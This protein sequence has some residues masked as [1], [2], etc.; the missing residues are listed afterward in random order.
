MQI[1]W[2]MLA[3][4]IGQDSKGAIT[5]IGVNQTV[6]GTPTL[7]A[8]TKRSLLSHLILSPGETLVLGERLTFH[9]RMEAPS[10]KTLA[11]SSGA[12]GIGS[13]PP[14]PEL[15][16]SID[17][18]G[19][20]GFM[21]EEYGTHRLVIEVTTPDGSE[22]SDSVNLYVVRP[23]EQNAATVPQAVPVPSA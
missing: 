14:W 6:F 12:I 3:E 16:A 9:V 15:P 13:L 4:G 21:V 8:M 2:T 20:V 19:E 11:A 10:G 5:L 1:E 7:P 23:I 18:P 17:I 22:L